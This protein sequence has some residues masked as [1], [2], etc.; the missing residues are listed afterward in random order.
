[1][2]RGLFG[3]LFDTIFFILK[4]GIDRE[5]IYEIDCAKKD[6]KALG[7]LIMVED[8]LVGLLKVYHILSIKRPLE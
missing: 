1:M 2:I 4:M 5:R 3:T 8:S 6:S 7:L